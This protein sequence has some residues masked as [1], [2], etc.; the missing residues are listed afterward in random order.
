MSR[1]PALRFIAVRTRHA[2]CCFCRFGMKEFS[3]HNTFASR[4]LPA[5]IIGGRGRHSGHFIVA[6]RPRAS[7]AFRASSARL[8]A[9][10]YAASIYDD[11]T[12]LFL[13]FGERKNTYF[14]AS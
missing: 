2:R 9:M 10:P 1:S 14:S 3:L 11:D 7:G 6:H 12:L 13:A 8:Y 5:I 4:A